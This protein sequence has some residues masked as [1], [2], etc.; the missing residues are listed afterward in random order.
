[1]DFTFPITVLK[2]FIRKFKLP[3]DVCC[4]IFSASSVFFEEIF[5]LLLV[6]PLFLLSCYDE[7]NQRKHFYQSHCMR[8]FQTSGESHIRV[9][10]SSMLGWLK[11]IIQV[12]S[13]ITLLLNL[14]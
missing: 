10:L 3:Q 12:F 4:F 8:F 7:I 1:M 11:T 14:V 5:S 6:H 9:S 2:N 13:C